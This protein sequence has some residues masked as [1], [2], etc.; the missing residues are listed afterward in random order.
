MF[1]F[2]LKFLNSLFSSKRIQQFYYEILILI[3][4]KYHRSNNVFWLKT[5]QEIY[6][7]SKPYKIGN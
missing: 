3:I 1:S 6:Y 7:Y 2:N 5:G 4:K